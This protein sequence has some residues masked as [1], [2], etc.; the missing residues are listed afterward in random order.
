MNM[1][2]LC[3]YVYSERTWVRIVAVSYVHS[4]IQV[5]T[6]AGVDKYALTFDMPLGRD[7]VVAASGGGFI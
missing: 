3:V 5:R 1:G 4:S 2:V 6:D 7:G